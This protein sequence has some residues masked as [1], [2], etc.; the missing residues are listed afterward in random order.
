MK[1]WLK[2]LIGVVVVLVAV[3]VYYWYD[4]YY[5]CSFNHREGC[6]VSCETDSDCGI[7]YCSC[8]NI[9]EEIFSWNNMETMCA[10][11]LECKCIDN[12]CGGAE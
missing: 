1:T 6:D 12:V 8:I 11:D 10:P 2:I 3:G 7:A 5:R 9:D 4:N